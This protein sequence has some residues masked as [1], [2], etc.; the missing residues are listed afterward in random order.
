MATILSNPQLVATPA[1]G[2]LRYGLFTAATVTD[3]LDARAIAAGVQWANL[4]CGPPLNEYDANCVTHP[5][6]EFTEGLDY[7]NAEP[8]WFY[9]LN[10]CGTVGRTPAEIEDAVRRWMTGGE[11]TAVESVLW[12][13]GDYG[14]DP[15]LTTAPDV[16]VVTP[17]APGAGAALAALEASFYAAYGYLGTIHV[18]MAAYG[19]L[20]DY[21]D[22]TGGAGVL[23]TELGSKVSYGAGYGV[24][25]P[26]GAAPAAGFVWA[27]MTPNVTVRRSPMM[28]PPV[29]DTLD[30]ITNQ[31]N[32]LAERV[33]LH[34]WTCDVVH[35][36]QIPLAAPA[37]S[38]PPAV[39]A[40]PE[41]PEGG[42]E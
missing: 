1:P 41:L 21:A 19:A 27:F 35:A 26:S 39:P 4:D 30:R 14:T 23:T 6:K 42:N 2:P 22:R 8:Y 13:G 12:S 36:V 34:S 17:L 28:V 20:A 33:Y 3:D 10:R 24:D 18:N 40:A 15:A 31:Y 29:L 5:V 32:A 9:A 25:G 37:A 38:V 7:S 11:Q 16:T